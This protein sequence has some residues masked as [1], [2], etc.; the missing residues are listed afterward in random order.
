MVEKMFV[1]EIKNLDTHMILLITIVMNMI[2]Y[3]RSRSKNYFLLM[4]LLLT[5]FVIHNFNTFFLMLSTLS[6]IHIFDNV[7]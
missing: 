1:I 4:T 3:I 7:C 5:I 2:S 6:Q